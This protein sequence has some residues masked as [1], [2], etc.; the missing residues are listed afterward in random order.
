M[1]DTALP[2]VCLVRHGET[3]WTMTGQR[4]GRTDIH[5]TSRGEDEARA[6][7]V[8]LR[9]M[10][11]SQVFTSPLQRAKRTCEL[12]G[13]GAEATV[14]ADLLEWDYGDY[15]G[16]RTL[17]IRADRPG[18]DLF[19]DGCPNGESVADVSARADRVIARVRQGGGHVLLFAHR[20]IFRVVASRWLGLP[21]EQGRRFY[22]DTGALSIL[23]YDHS[24]EEPVIRLWNEVPT[25]IAR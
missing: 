11:F 9:R 20:D 13:F 2:S 24:L 7:G 4:T 1:G 25:P 6:L 16:R 19:A 14:D 12:A 15:E 18:W 17:E 10:P 8:P 3:E 5:L 23:G 22:L 21:A